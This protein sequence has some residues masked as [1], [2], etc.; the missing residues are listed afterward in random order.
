MPLNAAL[1][2][3]SKRSLLRQD[4]ACSIQ[5]MVHK[6]SV[7]LHSQH[8]EQLGIRFQYLRPRTYHPS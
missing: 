6:R 4:F 2:I 5:K 8:D 7:I 1:P 3:R